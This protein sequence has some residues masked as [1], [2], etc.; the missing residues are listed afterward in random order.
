M[1]CPGVQVLLAVS[2][3]EPLLSAEQHEVDA[4]LDGCAD[5]M[6][7]LTENVLIIGV[8]RGLGRIEDAE[9]PPPIPEHLVRR[10]LAAHRAEMAKH[11][12]GRHSG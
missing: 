4:H 9:L 11:R 10:V 2:M 5:C 8:L 7:W 12:K 1:D 6:Q 3:D